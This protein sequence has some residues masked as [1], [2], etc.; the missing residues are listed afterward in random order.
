MFYLGVVDF[1]CVLLNSIISGYFSIMGTVYCSNE[2]LVYVTGCF[3]T[4]LWSTSC[5]AC[6]LLAMNR[7][8][9]VIRPRTAEWLFK[10]HRTSLLLLFP[11]AYFLYFLFFT[12]PLLFSSRSYAMFFNPFIDI[13][14]YD[15]EIEEPKYANISH[16]FNNV[17]DV[18]LLSTTYAVF[19]GF[20]VKSST[21]R[22]IS[23]Q[24]KTFIQATTICG[25]NATAAIIY[26]LMQFM[27]T[28]TVLIVIGQVAWQASHGAPVFIYLFVNRSI[29]CAVLDFLGIEYIAAKVSNFTDYFSLRQ[30][31]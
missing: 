23:L 14:G 22:T 3:G 27:P 26:V 31:K 20:I 28:P 24:Q 4:A 30:S 17:A 10:G 16:T 21:S 6:I 29:R 15:L 18:I 9:T 25:I 2:I 5:A 19:C 13:P 12:K 8:L 7:C 11:V 1:A